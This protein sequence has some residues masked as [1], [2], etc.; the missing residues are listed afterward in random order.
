MSKIYDVRDKTGLAVCEVIAN[1]KIRAVEIAIE[2]GY[3]SAKYAKGYKLTRE[4][5]GVIN[6]SADEKKQTT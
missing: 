2:A 4:P 5:H 3:H 6:S 1:S